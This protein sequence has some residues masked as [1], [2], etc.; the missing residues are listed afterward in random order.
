MARIGVFVERYTVANS[1]E[2]G[3]LMRF[4]HVAQLRGHH[5]DV[6][7]RPDIYKIPRYDALFVRSLTDPLNAAYVAAET[8]KLHGLRVIDDPQS[9]IVCCDKVHMY[10]KLLNAEV[11]MPETEFLEK[12]HLTLDNAERILERFGR[13]VVL[14]AP[15]SSFSM[16]VDRVDTAAEFLAVGKRYLRRANVVVA[17]RFVRSSYDWRVGV[18]AGEPLYACKYHIPKAHWKILTHNPDGSTIEGRTDAYKLSEVPQGLLD[19]AVD[20]CNAIGK[21]LYGVDIKQVGDKFL[22]IEVN[23]NPTIA[24]GDEDKASPKLYERIVSYLAGEWG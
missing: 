9:I 1:K 12:E 5:V 19:T 11:P 24:E 7:F 6:L 14:K 3:A 10:R 2:M 22:T 4:S 20:A 13:P 16:Y 8:A 21:S 23:D 15:N 18:L 17:Q